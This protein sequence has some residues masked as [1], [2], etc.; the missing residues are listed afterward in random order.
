M[1][2]DNL[3]YEEGGQLRDRFGRKQ[4]I[5]ATKHQS[6]GVGEFLAGGTAYDSDKREQVV[7][8][9]LNGV[10]EGVFNVKNY[11]AKGDGT[12]DDTTSVQNA[13]TAAKATGGTVY[14]PPGIYK[15][16]ATLDTNNGTGG[17]KPIR[18]TGVGGREQAG[19]GN[20]AQINFTGASGPAIKAYSVLCWELDH[21]NIKAGNAS[22]SGHVIDVDGGVLFQDCIQ[23]SIHHCGVGTV[24]SSTTSL[25]RFNKAIIGSVYENHFQGG[26]TNL[27]RLGDPSGSYVVGVSFHDN[28]YNLGTDSHI[29][30]G[31]GDLESVT[32]EHEVFE[33][34]P[35]GTG[36]AGSGS[37]IHG[38]GA[39]LWRFALRDCWFGDSSRAGTWLKDLNTTSN[40]RPAI[41]EGNQFET[42]GGST[43][44]H[45][46]LGGNWL[47]IGNVFE[48]G[49]IFDS[50][51]SSTL[52]VTALSNSFSTVTAI[53]SGN[54]P[55]RF[56]SFNNLVP[57]TIKEY[58]RAG[59]RIGFMAYPG[60]GVFPATASDEH[61]IVGATAGAAPQALDA[62]AVYT[63]TS[64][65]NWFATV[66]QSPSTP[67]GDTREV[68]LVAGATPTPVVRVMKD[69]VGFYNTA[70]VAR[71]AAYTLNAGATSR[72]LPAGGVVLDV[73]K[74]L[75]QL[76]TD[77][78]TNG[79]LQ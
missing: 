73:E 63:Y 4:Y 71:S 61:L 48:D 29:L 36:G 72:N 66:V 27:L 24:S 57:N 65:G 35:P 15:T 44:T 69:K 6:L 43:G 64:G 12:T 78:Q 18:L 9:N 17:S 70:P 45:A 74:V 79:L 49:T 1:A 39:Q 26:A 68:Q 62:G 19:T 41:I 8:T 54:R 77:L 40:Y 22:H 28:T 56:V 7:F 60:G 33:D 47:I 30:I 67:S 34:M 55:D 59:S 51:H 76:I 16:T 23:W 38:N 32:I 13:I 46:L 58:D 20:A 50:T 21:L 53:W 3:E 42:P 10:M 11:G 14:F 52:T 2:K 5:V 75:R 31:S 25:V 37:S